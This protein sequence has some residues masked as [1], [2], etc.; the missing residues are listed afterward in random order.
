MLL[1]LDLAEYLPL[2]REHKVA[3][4]DTFLCLSESDLEAMG[5][6]EVGA[7]KKISD[8]IFS[9]HKK[10]WTM[11][12]LPRITPRDK[13]GGC[14]LYFLKTFGDPKLKVKFVDEAVTLMLLLRFWI[15]FIE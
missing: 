5:V 10:E 9:I 1:G 8:G 13:Q 14:W 11:D 3:A 12:S 2:F 4:I 6:A 15:Q 7:R